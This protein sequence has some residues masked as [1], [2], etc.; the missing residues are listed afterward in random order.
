MCPLKAPSVL[1]LVGSHWGTWRASDSM[2]N[3]QICLVL[4]KTTPNCYLTTDLERS[5]DS[6]VLMAISVQL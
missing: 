6:G 1:N 3:D 2:K 4:H 5:S